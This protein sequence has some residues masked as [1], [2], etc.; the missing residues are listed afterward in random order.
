M[1]DMAV[2]IDWLQPVTMPAL[3]SSVKC[4]KL[5]TTDKYSKFKKNISDQT[6]FRT[7]FPIKY[8]T[9]NGVGTGRGGE[10]DVIPVDLSLLIKRKN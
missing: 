7:I 10:L 9:P 1:T 3:K 5:K 4:L 8:L 6:Q 2:I